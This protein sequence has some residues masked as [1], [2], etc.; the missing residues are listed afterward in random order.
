MYSAKV[1][2]SALYPR[3]RMQGEF[4]DQMGGGFGR[5]CGFDG[6]RRRRRR[7]ET[8]SVPPA[9][10]LPLFNS[11]KLGAFKP[12]ITAISHSQRPLMGVRR[13]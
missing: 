10:S 13:R 12:W 11:P 3:E 4:N 2:I 8:Y 7:R 6:G 5:V 1:R 9:E